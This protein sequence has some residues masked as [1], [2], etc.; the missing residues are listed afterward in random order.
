MTQGI[1]RHRGGLLALLVLT[2]SL[3]ACTSGD[4]SD[5]QRFIAETKASKK[6]RVE[7]LPE[8]VPT[9]S[10][11][12]SAASLDDPFVSWEQKAARQEAE[13]AKKRSWSATGWRP[14]CA[15]AA[16]HWRIFHWIPCA[17]SAP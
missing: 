13:M 10:F 14:M 16:S 17:W 8:F 12:Y 4:V 3:T 11:R 7:P 15:G 5:L 1:T 2:T 9:E 6:G